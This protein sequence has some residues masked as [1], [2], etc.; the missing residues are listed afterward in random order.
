MSFGQQQQTNNNNWLESC[1]GSC[2]LLV[3]SRY[4]ICSRSSIVMLQKGFGVSEIVLSNL[5][6]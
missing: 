1:S 3:I 2:T 4:I 6:T 5:Q